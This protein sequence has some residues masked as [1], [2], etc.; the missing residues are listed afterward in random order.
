MLKRLIIN[1]L[2]FLAL[3]LCVSSE[4]RAQAQDYEEGFGNIITIM[5]SF[6][7][8]GNV[9]LM[10]LGRVAMT[11]GRTVGRAGSAW[12]RKVAKAFKKVDV[13]YMLD[14]GDSRPD[15]KETIEEEITRFLPEENLVKR[16]AEGGFA[17]DETFGEVSEDGKH[18][19]NLVIIL[20]GQS[21]VALKG[22]VL[23][24]DVDRIVRRLNKQL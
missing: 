13:V 21:T 7:G 24:S 20:Y 4:L 5:E 10:K 3:G 16:D 8:K 17:F 14:Y 23:A 22:S 19:T 6:D 18:V 12:T 9:S 15:I 2:P 1:I 11:M